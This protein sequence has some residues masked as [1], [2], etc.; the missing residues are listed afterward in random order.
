MVLLFIRVTF[1]MQL[2]FDMVGHPRISLLTVFVVDLN[3]PSAVQMDTIHNNDI[4]DLAADL[5]S[6][7]CHGYP[8]SPPFNL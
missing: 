4:Q 3:M 5:L 6:E 2:H 8:L 7:V 1:V